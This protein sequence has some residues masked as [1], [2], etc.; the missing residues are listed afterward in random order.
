MDQGKNINL[1]GLIEKISPEEELLEKFAPDSENNKSSYVELMN[2]EGRAIIP[3]LVDCHTHLLWSG[4]G[5]NEIRMRRKW[6]FLSRI[7][8]RWRDSENC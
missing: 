6:S 8:R 5:S 1:D 4:D 7:P 3:G 2:V